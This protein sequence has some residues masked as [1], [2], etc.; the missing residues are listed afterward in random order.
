MPCQKP[1]ES[2]TVLVIQHELGKKILGERYTFTFL[3]ILLNI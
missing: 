3:V 2:V 1:S